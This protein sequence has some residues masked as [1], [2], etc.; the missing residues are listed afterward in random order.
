VRG[1]GLFGTFNDAVECD[2]FVANCDRK[3]DNRILVCYGRK[4]YTSVL[5]SGRSI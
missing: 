2:C 4:R 3:N 5:G 1:V